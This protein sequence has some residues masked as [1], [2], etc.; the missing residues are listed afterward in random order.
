MGPISS[1][2]NV[3]TNKKIVNIIS[4]TEKETNR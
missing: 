3:E 1:R 2:I 4:F